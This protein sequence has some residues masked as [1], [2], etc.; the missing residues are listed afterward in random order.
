LLISEILRRAVEKTSGTATW[1]AGR[2][3]PQEL[4]GRLSAEKE[5]SLP[6]DLVFFP[7]RLLSWGS[8]SSSLLSDEYL[9]RKVRSVRKT[10]VQRVVFTFVT[11]PRAI[12]FD[13]RYMV[14]GPP[15]GNERHVASPR[16]QN[17]S[18]FQLL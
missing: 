18:E 12:R 9:G 13:L 2:E 3:R 1:A 15:P 5:G 8:G 14:E 10:T 6:P 17:R 16:C 4:F 7:R 11:A